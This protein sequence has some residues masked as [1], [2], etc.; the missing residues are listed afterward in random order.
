MFISFAKSVSCYNGDDFT[1]RIA[2]QYK[3]TM[4]WAT[5]FFYGTLATALVTP[6]A[7]SGLALPFST[8]GRNIVDSNG[9]N[10]LYQGTNWPGHLE[11]MIPEGLNY[12]SV[13]DIVSKIR[14]FGLN[15]VRLT[16]AIEMV[17]DIYSKGHDTGLLDSLT[18][19]VGQ[20][21][22]TRI[23]GQI[24]SKNPQFTANT[25]RLQVFDAVAKELAAQ[26]IATHLD[27]HVSKAI[28]CCLPGDGNGWWG[29]RFFNSAN[30]VRGWAYMAKHG[31]ANWP[32]FASVGLRN[33]VRQAIFEGEPYDWYTWNKHMTAGAA[34]VHANA[35]DVLIFFGGMDSATDDSKLP[36]GAPL[37]GTPLT[38]TGGKVAHFNP[39]ALPY[40]RKVVL[41]IH[42]YDT[43]VIP[44]AGP[45][46]L[47]KWDFYNK[48]FAALDGSQK[49][50][51]PIVMSE[52]GFVQD[53][54]Y[55]KKQYNQC[56]LEFVQEHKFGYMQWGL[57]GSYYV[58]Q[59]TI[60]YDESW[61]LLD[62]RWSSTRSPI[63]VQNSLDLMSSAL[64]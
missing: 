44:Y 58:R 32:S 35:P 40:A 20:G 21:N 46:S 55:Y 53:G 54:K 33:E 29:E 41:E 60:D 1:Y 59:G 13:Q 24:I 47:W 23:F 64:R 8:S 10:F 61:G 39:E 56:L 52:Y 37:Y 45:C 27:N 5:L 34:A 57:E 4:R 3:D 15:S 11:A 30:W 63:T 28:W 43:F 12:A 9:N 42:K 50:T 6:N 51:L 18:N 16:Y 62:H 7:Q 25:T 19:A 22:G 14:G 48:G 17:D 36:Q 38:S 31:A 26:G 2:M 49:Y